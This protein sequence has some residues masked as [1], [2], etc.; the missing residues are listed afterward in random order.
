M[1][2]STVKSGGSDGE[3]SSRQCR[4]RRF[5]PW[6]R[7]IPWRRKWQPTPLFLP[8]ESRGQR[9]L[10]GYSPQDRKESGTTE[11]LNTRLSQTLFKGLLE[12]PENTCDAFLDCGQVHMSVR[13][14]EGKKADGVKL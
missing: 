8:G 1:A 4:R 5:D 14:L 10:V 2:G 7:K 13:A 11:R 9:S 6:I 12:G 3:E